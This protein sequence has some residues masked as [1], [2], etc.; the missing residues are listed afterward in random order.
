MMKHPDRV[1]ATGDHAAEMERFGWPVVAP[2][3]DGLLQSINRQD[4]KGAP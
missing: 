1:R 2:Q 3:L 4:A